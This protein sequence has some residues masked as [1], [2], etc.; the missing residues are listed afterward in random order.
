MQQSAFNTFSCNN[1]LMVDF[2]AVGLFVNAKRL[3]DDRR[4][5]DM[6][7]SVFQFFVDVYVLQFP[8]FICLFIKVEC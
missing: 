2:F 6:G 7:I 1:S 5:V 8:A 4:E 3:V